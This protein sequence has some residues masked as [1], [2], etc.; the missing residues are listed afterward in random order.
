MQGA[1]ASLAPGRPYARLV[2]FVGAA[3]TLA[4]AAPPAARAQE[5]VDCVTHTGAYAVGVNCR[6]LNVDG[7]PRHFI[8][9]VP[10]TRPSEAG[11]PVV[12]MFHGSS[13]DGEQFL[14]ISGWREQADAT[15]LVAVF[16]T[17]L[18]YRMLDSGRRITKWNDG[19]LR[20]QIDL[21]D[22][23]PGYPSD[24]P[25][26]ADDVG[27]VDG[28]LAD[29]EARLA[30]DPSRVYASGF[31]N[32]ANFTA[33]LAVERST[34]FA[35]AAFAAGELQQLRTPERPIPM[36]MT[37]GTRDDRL[38][39][40]TGLDELPLD[41]AA[42]L[43]DPVLSD[44]L[45]T[46]LEAL[47]LDPRALGVHTAPHSTALSWP[48]DGPGADGAEF[49]FTML[50]GLE[51]RYPR[52]GNNPADFAAAPEFWRFFDAHRLSARAPAR[53]SA[54]PGANGII[55]VLIG[56]V[57]APGAP[58]AHEFTPPIGTDKGS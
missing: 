3:L 5:P 2:A 56:A 27:F 13:G 24:A 26:P 52:V 7:Y 55:A 41:P 35:A 16:P 22:R 49:H 14:R 32:G 43:A 51:H 39:A 42:I 40:Q 4:V 10:A 36:S 9:Y 28:M 21:Q 53:A 30:I 34:V 57:A 44:A 54:S 45:R 23:P 29:V 46:H 11:A 25:F 15:G 58:P 31:S 19:G 18:R 17:G 47:G 8:V 37:L 6:E 1:I 33:R 50:E 12:F 38:L 48:A 20:T